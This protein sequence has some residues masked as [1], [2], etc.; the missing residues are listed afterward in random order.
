MSRWPDFMFTVV[1]RFICGTVLG[2]LLCLLMFYR[3]VLR[4][5]SHNHIWSVVV[6]L[7]LWGFGGGLVAVF[8][9]PKWQ[10]PWYKGI[11]DRNR[12]NDS[13]GRAKY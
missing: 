4:S 11:R 5:F 10:T 13:S 9:I 1:I 7:G 12:D 8:T 3:G 2:G 6:W